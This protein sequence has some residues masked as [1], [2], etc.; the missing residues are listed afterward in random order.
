MET[1]E[2]SHGETKTV[3]LILTFGALSVGKQS[4]DEN[5]TQITLSLQNLY[6]LREK[7][8]ICDFF[9]CSYFLYMKMISIAQELLLSPTPG[10]F[11]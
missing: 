5:T 8:F 2:L 9:T 3:A 11:L 6:I 7:Y 1:T 10:K 4:E